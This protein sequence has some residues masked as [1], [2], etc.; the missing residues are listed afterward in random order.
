MAKD[1]SHI[2]MFEIDHSLGPYTMTEVVLYNKNHKTP[3]EALEHVSSGEYSD[4]VLSI[5]KTQWIGLFCND[6]ED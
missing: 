1:L 6:K 3:E 2:M 5:P 4:H